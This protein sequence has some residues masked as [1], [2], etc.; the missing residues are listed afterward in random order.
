MNRLKKDLAR[1]LKKLQG[2]RMGSETDIS[3]RWTTQEY[4]K[5]GG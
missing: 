4:G 3:K 1:T 2:C 5:L